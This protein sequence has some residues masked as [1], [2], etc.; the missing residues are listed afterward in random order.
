MNRALTTIR[1]FEGVPIHSDFKHSPWFSTEQ[2]QADWFSQYERRD[3]EIT[4]SSYANFQEQIRTSFK[5]E[6]CANVN[7]L[8]VIA[9][10]YEGASVQYDKYYG[11]VDTEPTYDSDGLL[12]FS[13]IC[14]P[15]QTLMF[16]TTLGSAFTAKKTVRERDGEKLID[17]IELRT[18]ENV[19]TSGASV[20]RRQIQMQFVPGATPNQERN[21]VWLVIVAQPNAQQ[22][23]SSKAY[24]FVGVPGQM[25]YYAVPF[26]ASTGSLYYCQF[27]NSGT[28]S[29]K[30]VLFTP[31]NDTIQDLLALVSKDTNFTG[32]SSNVVNSYFVPSLGIP[33]RFGTIPDVGKQGLMID[34]PAN[35]IQNFPAEGI[36][37]NYA[38]TGYRMIS[39]RNMPNFTP[40]PSV[41]QIA[42]A[43]NFIEDVLNASG[44][45]SVMPTGRIPAKCL[46]EPFASIVFSDSRGTEQKIDL[47]QMADIN[48]DVTVERI[49]SLGSSPKIEYTFPG[50]RG[51]TGEAISVSSANA[52]DTSDY[53]AAIVLDA[54]VAYYQASKNQISVN[55]ANAAMAMTN[56]NISNANAEANLQIQQSTELKNLTSQQSQKLLDTTVNG[57]GGVISGAAQ[58]GG[59]GAIKGGLGALAGIAGV[60]VNSSFESGRMQNTLGMQRKVLANNISANRKIAKN[61]YD[62]AVASI[63]AGLADAKN[64]TNNVVGSQ[65]EASFIFGNGLLLPT[66]SIYTA[67]AAEVRKAS[68]YWG[69]QGYVSGDYI[70]VGSYMSDTSVSSK[71]R[72]IQ[73]SGLRCTGKIAQNFREQ[74]NAIFDAG[75]TM[76]TDAEA[77]KSLKIADNI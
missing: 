26:D 32:T 5:K 55:K 10:T 61:G 60:A 41:T 14:D 45:A 63:N 16:R 40:E 8:E 42:A 51:S 48:G 18:V 75:I 50:L 39:I 35:W 19:G 59:A 15:L 66:L 76:W 25:I 7:Y 37:L 12:N 43:A 28:T 72:Y 69:T 71:F 57:I 52:Y 54:Y 70:D 34:P 9:P 58:G 2:A 30:R 67:P 21:I 65:G 11:F 24:S 29:D 27:T 62:M 3:L 46:F 23:S 22:I 38:G 4:D 53:S 33:Q 77:F 36:F 47:R 73:T 20:L 6:Q 49:V 13:W 17:S 44:G 31:Q 1:F 64:M 56:N 74:I 68:L